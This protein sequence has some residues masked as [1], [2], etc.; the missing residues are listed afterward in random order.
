MLARVATQVGDD[1]ASSEYI[2]AALEVNPTSR[3]ALLLQV[4][5]NFNKWA[6]QETPQ[7]ILDGQARSLLIQA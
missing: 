7:L 5:N 1:T 6:L 4:M 3:Q 2:E